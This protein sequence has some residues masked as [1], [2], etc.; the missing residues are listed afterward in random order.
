MKINL[1]PKERLDDL[2]IKIR[3]LLVEK[4]ETRCEDK[5]FELEE[6]PIL[7]MF[8]RLLTF[9]LE[10]LATSEEKG[11]Q[12]RLK[13][14]FDYIVDDNNYMPLVRYILGRENSIH[15]SDFLEQKS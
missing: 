15:Y 10:R 8:A 3:E 4:L 5:V 12:E 14:F 9:T 13:L 11:D 6:S 1:N 2:L 7:A